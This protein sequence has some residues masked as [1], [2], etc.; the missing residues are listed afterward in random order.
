[1]DTKEKA[2]WDELY[3]L[4]GKEKYRVPAKQTIIPVRCGPDMKTV[5]FVTSE[6]SEFTIPFET[7]TEAENFINYKE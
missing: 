2:L 5:F 4:T 6:G 1:M 3:A 7:R